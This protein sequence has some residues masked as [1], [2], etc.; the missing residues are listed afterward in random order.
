[1]KYKKFAILSAVF[2]TLT[3][4]FVFNGRLASIIKPVLA[5]QESSQSGSPASIEQQRDFN[6]I[7]ELSES[8]NLQGLVKLAN[9]I[10][11]KWSYDAK[12]YSYMMIEICG[13]L[14]S[15]DFKNNKQY[16]LTHKYA[17][18]ALQK[19]DQMPVENEIRLVQ[20][21]GGDIEYVTGQVKPEEWPQDRSERMKYWFHAWQRLN[22]E[23]DRNFN[24]NDRPLLNVT[25]P[26]GPYPS[27]IS[28]E[29]IKDSQLRA[30]YEAAIQA[31]KEK[32]ARFNRQFLLHRLDKE[33][34]ENLKRFVANAYARPPFDQTE[35]EYYLN[36][37]ITD[38]GLRQSIL[39]EVQLK[40][41]ENR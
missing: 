1:M 10:E 35:L 12:A 36:T 5:Q 28:P 7:K 40:R 9:E 31:N 6:R 21:L 24:F 3:A 14:A 16:L 37:Y 4:S 20:Y 18:L 2:A 23:I 13:S 26:S 8:R 32:A 15:Y 34:T 29:A 41:A 39:D 30:R 27:G 25:P 22:G 19:A 11:L 33:L 38:N 17:K